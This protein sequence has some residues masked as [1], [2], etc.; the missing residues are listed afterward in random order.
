MLKHCSGTLALSRQELHSES[1]TTSHQWNGNG[2]VFSCVCELVILSTVSG[3]SPLYRAFPQ[4]CSYFV[5]TANE[6]C[7]KVMFLHLSVSHSVH[8]GRGSVWLW[9][10]ETLGHTPW[11]PTPPEHTP[12]TETPLSIEAGGAH[13]TGMHSCSLCSPYCW[14]NGRLALDWNAFL[15]HCICSWWEKRS[16][17]KRFPW[18]DTTTLTGATIFTSS[19]SRRDSK[20]LLLLE[21]WN[22]NCESLAVADPGFPRRQP[23]R[24]WYR[25][26]TLASF[27]P[28]TAW[29]WKI[30]TNGRGG[31]R[32]WPPFGYANVLHY[33]ICTNNT[34]FAV[35]KYVSGVQ[36]GS[37]WCSVLNVIF[38]RTIKNDWTYSCYQEE[39]HWIPLT[40]RFALCQN[41]G[42]Q[43]STPTCNKQLLLHLFTRCRRDT[44]YV[45]EQEV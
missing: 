39:I 1:F 37:V 41:H 17:R 22:Y 44:V 6:V 4:T 33:N 11:T 43:C 18:S 3:G 32:L 40:M 8:G 19:S 36:M 31:G 27:P 9:V 35:E 26:V 14:K 7:C 45:F 12:W 16:N 28:Q 25:P 29:K 42:Q 34:R 15:F 24:W 10:R 30:W 21:A 2:I 5:P 38:L 20:V 13:P 23:K